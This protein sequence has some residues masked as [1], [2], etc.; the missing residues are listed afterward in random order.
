MQHRTLD[1]AEQNDVY[2]SLHRQS[3]EALIALSM[4]SQFKYHAKQLLALQN[5]TNR[6]GES[7]AIAT[8]TA[9][10]TACV[11]FKKAHLCFT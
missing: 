3:Q 1:T 10:I 9:L 2:M 5:V 8:D 11:A 7:A 6:L 4:Y